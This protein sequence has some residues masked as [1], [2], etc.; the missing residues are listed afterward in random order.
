MNPATSRVSVTDMWD[1]V[2]DHSPDAA[3]RQ[4]RDVESSGDTG[5]A[6]DRDG[7]GEAAASVEPIAARRRRVRSAIE[8]AAAVAVV[9]VL[10]AAGYGGWQ[11]FQQHQT[12]V[13]A[14]QALAAAHRYLHTMTNFNSDNVSTDIDEN[15]NG[16]L[17]GSTGEFREMYT[18]SRTRLLSDQ[19]DDNSAARGTVVDSAVKSAT[20]NKVVLVMLVDEAVISQ[21]DLDTTEI[22]RARLRMTMEKVDGQ[23]LVSKMELP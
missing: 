21:G 23:W 16:L 12:D 13:A 14:Q 11:A 10:A 9:A 15:M 19:L 2:G 4:V 20:K 8:W 3:K 22:D 1:S 17:D 7:G 18:H 5:S 6:D